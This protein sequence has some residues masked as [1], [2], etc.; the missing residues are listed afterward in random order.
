[1]VCVCVCAR[2]TDREAS[3]RLS[4]RGAPTTAARAGESGRVCAL[5]YAR[6]SFRRLASGTMQCAPARA[7][8]LR[9]PDKW[10]RCANSYFLRCCGATVVCEGKQGAQIVQ[11][12]HSKPTA[13]DSRTRC[14]TREADEMMIFCWYC[15]HDSLDE[16]GPQP[17]RTHTIFI[18][19]IDCPVRR[20]KRRDVCYKW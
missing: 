1:V 8:A 2:G 6:K 12:N 14:E 20:N 17:H 5:M 15:H 10:A 11:E 13:G 3:R 4:A 18:N 9:P 19:A 7:A 16:F